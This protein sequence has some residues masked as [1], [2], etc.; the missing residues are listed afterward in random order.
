MS[1]VV[2]AIPVSGDIKL[3][4]LELCQF[5][6]LGKVQL[7]IDK[8]TTIL[9]GAN[10]SGKT[11]VLA[12]LRH[13][14]ADGSPFGA[15][16]ISLSQWPTLRSLGKTWEALTDDPLTVAGDEE[17]WKEQFETLLSTMPTLDLWFDAEP[18]M[19]HYVAPFLSK[20]S[21][22][23]GAVGIRL[24]LEPASSVEELKQL[25]WTYHT[26]R[27]PVKDMG[28]DSLAW[29]IDLLDFWLREPS[30]LGQVCAYKLDAENNPLA[31]CKTYITQKLAA[32]A[33][34]IER[35]HL[36]K[37]I[38]VDFVAAQRGLGSEEAESRSASGPHRVGMFSNQLLKFAR[39]HLN[40]A[41]TGHGHRTDLIKAVAEAQRELDKKIHDAIADSVEEVKELG[42][43]GLHDPQ[44][45]RFRTR[46]QTADL[47]DHGTAVQYSMQKDSLEELLPE[48]S[49]GLGYQNLQSLSYQL[50][51]FKAARLK[52]EKGAPA[53]V[54]LVMIEEPEAHLH[55]QV[56]RIFPDK[57]HKLISPTDADA[58]ALKSQLL[59]STHSSHL[60]HAED[61]DRLRYVRRIAKSAA[62][63]M[64]TTEVVNL[65][66]VFGNDKKTRQFAER[67]F[68]VQ[69]TDL[70][71][72]N[73]A[74]FVEGV[75]ERMLVPLF[76]ERDFEEL[77]S[78]YISFLDIGGSHAHRLKPLV[79]KLRIP[80]VIITDVDPCEEQDG[81]PKKNGEPT[82][83][84]V[85]VAN[86]G[87]AGLHCGNPTLRGWHPKLQSLEDFKN[88]TDA[89]LVWSENADCLV[90]FAWQ[91]PVA[92]AGGSWP[93]SFEDS[94][95][96]TNIPWFKSLM[97]EKV[98]DDGV[99]VE[100]PT[101]ALGSVAKAVA[102][103]GSVA[104]MV[105]ELHT[106]M[107][108]SLN[109]GEFAASIF[110]KLSFGEPVACPKYIADAL[111]W[112]QAQLEPSKEST[113]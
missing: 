22:K 65:G 92:E 106:V 34:P 8:K 95:V 60:A 85:A 83:K 40:V 43:P 96:L 61:F 25:A 69:H 102:E 53:P 111:C 39:Q 68:R 5:R 93:S 44:E 74:I 71:F 64:P 45:I 36:S 13:F 2:P 105:A 7:D 33:S 62:N 14:L 48:H 27:E 30:K 101:G 110:E 3:R 24:R 12:A 81:K 4:F 99:D 52:P 1:R 109:K 77:N 16:D 37:V 87:Q 46:I 23:G 84:L 80:T 28:A 89:Q 17:Q 94:L 42:Y 50:V 21:W 32:D 18:G 73:A 47:L 86:M 6:R 29:P 72:A 9:V 58:S 90:R 91:L 56:Q 108:S 41:R 76:M 113:A 20:F 103:S 98:D 51:S 26:A 75:A 104:D 63:P 97:E 100:P 54:H 19:Y 67:Y 107:H 49:I 78:R 55:V 112:L 88:P 35:K 59:I 38:R 70:L 10:N 79:E 15:F 11:S 31:G 57:A 82:K 66:Q